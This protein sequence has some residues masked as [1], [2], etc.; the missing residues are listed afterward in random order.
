MPTVCTGTPYAVN[1]DEPG[2][3]TDVRHQAGAACP[4]HHPP[5]P[6]LRQA[7]EALGFDFDRLAGEVLAR[8]VA[9]VIVE[10][11]PAVDVDGRIFVH[12]SGEAILAFYPA[13]RLEHFPEVI[14]RRGRPCYLVR[15]DE[16]GR[17]WDAIRRRHDAGQTTGAFVDEAAAAGLPHYRPA[18]RLRIVQSA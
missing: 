3:G 8:Y 10:V 1:P 12:C 13:R 2:E 18:P 11:R 7:V 5:L 15:D 14:E 16:D 4:V 9:D 17:R 6:T